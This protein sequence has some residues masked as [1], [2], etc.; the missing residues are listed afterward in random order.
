[1]WRDEIAIGA[2][3]IHFAR[4]GADGAR[5][6]A[7][8]RL[9]SGSPVFAPAIAWAGDGYGTI[10]HDARDRNNELYFARVRE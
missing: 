6:G 4:L 2:P 7:I 9:T 5:I 8:A 10:W 3:E 1:V